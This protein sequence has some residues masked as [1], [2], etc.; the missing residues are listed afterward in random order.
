MGVTVAAYGHT[1]EFPAFYVPSSGHYAP[2][3]VKTSHEAAQLIC[4]IY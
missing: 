3:L 2:Y 4:M 1:R